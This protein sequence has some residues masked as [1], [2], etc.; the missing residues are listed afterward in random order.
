MPDWAI[1]RVANL[2]NDPA[3]KP[4]RKEPPLADA[5]APPRMPWAIMLPAPLRLVKAGLC[6]NVSAIPI[7]KPTCI[8]VIAP[9][10]TDAFT[11]PSVTP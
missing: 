1:P 10:L 7:E 9:A 6:P 8:P 3:A 2:P 5:M 4:E 11:S